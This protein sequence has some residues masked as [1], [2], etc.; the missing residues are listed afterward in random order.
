[1][2]DRITQIQLDLADIATAISDKIKGDAVSEMRVG[3]GNS[4]RHYK[5]SEISLAELETKRAAL[6][7]ELDSLQNTQPGF[8]NTSFMRLSYNK[9]GSK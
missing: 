7:T 9:M 5:F 1:M 3:S 6:M 4:I 8:R 2:A